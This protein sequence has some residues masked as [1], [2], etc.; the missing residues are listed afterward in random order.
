MLYT[1]LKSLKAAVRFNKQPVGTFKR[2]G[3]DLRKAGT[4]LGISLIGIIVVNDTIDIKDGVILFIFGI[5]LWVFGHI[6]DYMTDNIE[7]KQKK[8]GGNI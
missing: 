7:L 8:T 3:N 6:C 1:K 5:F 4:L 2:L